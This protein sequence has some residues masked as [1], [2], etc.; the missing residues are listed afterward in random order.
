MR[1]AYFGIVRLVRDHRVVVVALGFRVG[2]GD[3][4][5]DGRGFELRENVQFRDEVRLCLP[6]SNDFVLVFLHA[7]ILCDVQMMNIISEILVLNV[8]QVQ[9][10]VVLG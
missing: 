9:F 2:D 8:N 10:D 3:M 7:F 1:A 4:I 5:V 6:Q